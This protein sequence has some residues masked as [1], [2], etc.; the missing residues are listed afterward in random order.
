M[1][2]LV[3]HRVPG[4]D[5]RHL[6]FDRE[7]RVGQAL[8]DGEPTAEPI[9][10]PP[11]GRD[12][13]VGHGEGEL[14]V[15]RVDAVGARR[16]GEAHSQLRASQPDESHR[17]ALPEAPTS[18]SGRSSPALASRDHAKASARGGAGALI[19]RGL[20]R[21]T[22]ATGQGPTLRT[23]RKSRRRASHS[24]GHSRADG[25][26]HHLPKVRVAGSNPCRPL[27]PKLAVSMAFLRFRSWALACPC[28]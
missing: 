23:G 1:H 6:G 2:V 4:V 3:A 14:G 9:E 5:R 22:S 7:G 11:D 16:D 17:A 26:E 8:A 24:A 27:Q 18:P 10:G 19:G 12:A 25:P 28:P 21:S 15:H 13:E 20:M